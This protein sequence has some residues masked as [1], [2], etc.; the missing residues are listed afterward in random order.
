MT[1]YTDILIIGGGAAGLMAAA[2]AASTAD[3]NGLRVTVL[4]KMPRVGRKI[5]ISGKGRCNFTN[6]S[7]WNEFSS[8]IHPKADFLKPAFYGLPPEKLTA[9]I[10][11]KGCPCV[12]ERGDRVF[13]ESHKSSDIV[14]ALLAMA[15]DAGAEIVTGC[16][17]IDVGKGSDSDS[18]GGFIVRTSA[19]EYRCRSLIITTGGLSYPATGSTGD[20]YRWA[21][22]LGHRL[23]VRFPS[24]TA[25]V[26]AGY[27]VSAAGNG[28]AL[29]GNVSSLSVRQ[30]AGNGAA[31]N[32][33][34]GN[35]AAREASP[36]GE[37]A[38]AEYCGMK[39]HIDRS[40][41]LSEWGRSLLGIS[42][43]NVR[44]SVT[45]G[46]NE[47]CSEFGDLDFTDGG[48]E[49]PIGF[50]VSRK[51]VKAVMNGAKITLHIDLK[52]AVSPEQLEKRIDELWKEIT[53]D[54]RSRCVIRGRSVLKPY[55]E[56]FAVLLSKLLPGELVRPFSASNPG[57]DSR[58][59]GR[60]LKDWR[61]PVAG[62]VGYERCVVTAG[63]VSLDEVNKKDMQSKLTPGLYFAGELLD[64]DGD[65]GGYNLHTAFCTG[66]LAGTKAAGSS[67]VSNIQSIT[68]QGHWSWS[69]HSCRSSYTI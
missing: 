7:G 25:V 52:P 3:G 53:E 15:R 42:L 67:S 24:L 10:E 65:T 62:Y 21:E 46:G 9:M 40:V 17:V 44:L 41:P 34:A 37:C 23:T 22:K 33:A 14:D 56:R 1:S 32:G 5:M 50:K 26:P 39:G 13:P 55:K 60:A 31:G 47:L 54:R 27:K 11:E 63:G 4:E 57:I 6:M 8:H 51:A 12:T 48:V 69:R 38:N 64:L 16:E 18:G 30:T 68:F 20:G 59:L 35:G 36:E 28:A 49:G 58:T 43:K 19:G 66:Y 45:D 29:S 61:L 2:G